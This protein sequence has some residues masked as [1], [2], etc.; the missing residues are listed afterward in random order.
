MNLSASDIS[1]V[2]FA[3]QLQKESLE[4]DFMSL[5]PKKRVEM[6]YTD[7]CKTFK[8]LQQ[9]LAVSNSPLFPSDMIRITDSLSNMKTALD[10][11]FDSFANDLGRDTAIAYRRDINRL[12]RAFRNAVS[13]VPDSESSN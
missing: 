3:V 12:L 11:D 9:K 2:R 10:N 13:S 5:P 4:A 7:F 8:D 6:G 1:I